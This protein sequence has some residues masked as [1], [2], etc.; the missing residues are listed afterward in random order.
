MATITAAGSGSGI[1]VEL[2][3]EKLTAAERE[4]VDNRLNLREVQIQADISAFNTLKGSLTDFQKA[5]S[6]L[7]NVKD[8]AVRTT[9]S[10]DEDVFT[11]TG[12]NSAVP[13]TTTIRIEKLA[14]AHKLVSQG[15]F[16]DSEAAVGNGTL[17][18]SVGVESFDVLIDPSNNTLAGVRDAI[19][20]AAD[21][22]GITASILTVD[23][24]MTPGSTISELVFTSNNSGASNAITIESIGD[25]DL[26]DTDNAGLSRL[27]YLPDALPTPITNLNPIT[28][29]QDAEIEVDGFTVTSSTNTFTG[30]IQGVTIN[31]VSADPGVDKTLTVNL[32]KSAVKEKINGFVDAFNEFKKTY[33]FLTAVDIEAQ[34]AG[35]LT[36]DATARSIFTQIRREI[37]NTVEGLTGNYN[38]LASAGISS[39]REG[40]LTLD[41]DVLTAALNTDFDKIGELFS[42]TSGVMNKLDDLFDSFLKSGGVIASK[43]TTLTTQLKDI[44]QQRADLNLR[45]ES[46]E[47]RLR[48]QFTNMDILVAQFNNTGDFLQQQMDAISPTKKK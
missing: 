19:N 2:L 15:S 29:A 48:Q 17:R 25:V 11:A 33:D 10:S 16:A 42:G 44:A 39:D 41:D 3:V 34:E 46:V 20:D 47:K 4:P 9:T 21:N 18:I 5:L 37:S 1:D 27:A 45:I 26:D 6:G 38:S 30:V 35:L 23:D 40:N 28:A 32:N 13:G 31:A 22:K 36:G 12:S 43:N 14:Q 24:P 8:F 7:T